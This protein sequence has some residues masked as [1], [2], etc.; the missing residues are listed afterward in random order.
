MTIDFRTGI[1]KQLDRARRKMSIDFTANTAKALVVDFNNLV[2]E[3]SRKEFLVVV[4]KIAK[5]ATVGKSVLIIY[6]SLSNAVSKQLIDRGFL[7]KFT[8]NQHDGDVTEIS[9]E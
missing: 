6:D 4:D 5:A 9:W 8:S 3:Q 1:E 7:V 2:A